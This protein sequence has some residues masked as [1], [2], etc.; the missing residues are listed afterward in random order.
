MT[1]SPA[2]VAI[3]DNVETLVARL[4]E[5][6]TTAA[7]LELLDNL[8]TLSGLLE[9]VGTFLGRSEEI[10]DNAADSLREM[11]AS[12]GAS[13]VGSFFGDVAKVGMQTL[14]AVGKLAGADTVKKLVNS[15]LLE[16]ATLDLLVAASDAIAAAR[17]EMP[18]APD[19]RYGLFS[20]AAE[21]KDPEVSAGLDFGIRVL[22]RLGATLKNKSQSEGSSPR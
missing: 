21:L 22:R 6:K 4:S 18:D 11:S 16:P 7:L 14:P 2:E 17:A 1:T 12:A 19:K 13:P 5:P 10:I 8:A 9:A 15:S 20:L 3:S